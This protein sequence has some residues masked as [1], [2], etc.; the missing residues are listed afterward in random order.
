MKNVLGVLAILAGIAAFIYVEIVWVWV[1]GIEELVRG[2]QAK[3]V[4]GHDLA[5]GFVRV[6]GPGEIVSVAAALVFIVPGVI[7]LGR[8]EKLRLKRRRNRSPR[9]INGG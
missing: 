8:Q 3:P 4:S 2:F 5:W 6:L 7:L 9:L 1:G